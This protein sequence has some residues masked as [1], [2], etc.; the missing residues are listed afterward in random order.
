MLPD[1]NIYSHNRSSFKQKP[2]NES[3]VYENID[4]RLKEIKVTL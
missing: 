2:E 4:L 3:I 1:I